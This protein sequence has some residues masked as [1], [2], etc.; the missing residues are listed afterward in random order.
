MSFGNTLAIPNLHTNIFRLNVAITLAVSL[1]PYGGHSGPS[2]PGSLQ[3]RGR[4][5]GAGR[6]R[7]QKTLTKGRKKVDKVVK[8]VYDSFL[9]FF[10]T[11]LLYLSSLPF[12]SL[13]DLFS[14]FFDPGPRGPGNLVFDF[15]GISG[16]KGPSD[17][18]KGPRRLQD[19]RHKLL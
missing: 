4:V 14:T 16:R 10:F 9:P 13:F 8:V 17:S 6:P 1:A 3:G 15:F 19:Y 18:C 7:G 2:G 12:S 5:A 11:F